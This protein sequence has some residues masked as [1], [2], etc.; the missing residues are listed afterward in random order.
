MLYKIEGT[1]SVMWDGGSINDVKYPKNIAALWSDA[2]LAALGLYRPVAADA[3]P[4]GMVATELQVQVIN[5]VVTEVNITQPIVI[6]AGQVKAEAGR[7]IELL[8]PAWKQRNMNAAATALIMT[9]VAG[10][11]WTAEEQAQADVLTAAWALVSSIRTAS[12][13]LEAMDPIPLDYSNNEYWM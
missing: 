7:R 1:K 2:E 12:D 8:F 5:G 10:G 11:S 13:V 9:R 6:N 4:D 3:V